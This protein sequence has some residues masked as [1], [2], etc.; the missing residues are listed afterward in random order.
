[1]A[2][3]KP[4]MRLIFRVWKYAQGAQPYPDVIHGLIRSLSRVAIFWASLRYFPIF[5]A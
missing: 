3:G 4:G 5:N 2:L 1:M